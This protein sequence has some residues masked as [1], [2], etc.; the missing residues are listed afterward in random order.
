LASLKSGVIAGYEVVDVNVEL[1]KIK[2]DDEASSEVAF[3]T[4]VSFALLDALKN[5]KPIL[6]EPIFKVEIVVPEEYVGDVISD[7]A[8]RKG[9]LDG[10][11]LV[12]GKNLIKSTIPLSNMFGYATDLRSKTQGRGYY[13]MIFDYF[14]QVSKSTLERFTY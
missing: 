2:Y 3:K 9:S 7:I 14:A 11:E 1:L 8:A 10:M 4:T 5:A 6:L 13:S 12:S